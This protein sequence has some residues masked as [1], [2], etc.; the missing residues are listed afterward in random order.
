[1]S[2]RA[3]LEGLTH[4]AG[5]P[6]VDLYLADRWRTRPWPGVE[7]FPPG[8][9][10]AWWV[11]APGRRPHR[12]AQAGAP[13]SAELD[14]LRPFTAYTGRPQSAGEG[15]ASMYAPAFYRPRASRGEWARDYR[16]AQALHAR[17]RREWR[18]LE[19]AGL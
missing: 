9:P 14:P 11:T 4:A 3:R 12:R 19:R 6:V 7:A 10:F 16:R 2:R 8:D 13:P 18:R 17:D 1:M 5:A 15:I